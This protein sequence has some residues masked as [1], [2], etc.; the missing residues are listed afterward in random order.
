MGKLQL[1]IKTILIL[2]FFTG[3]CTALNSQTGTMGGDFL[4]INGS[5]RSAA[6][7]GAFIAIADDPSAIYWNPAG[8]TQ[9]DKAQFLSTYMSWLADISYTDLSFVLP[10][11]NNCFGLTVNYL[12]AGQIEE[13]TS[14]NPDGTGRIF[15]PYDYF[16]T[17]SYARAVLPDFSFGI[18]G[19]WI[20]EMLDLSSVAGY[21]FD[22]GLLWKPTKLGTFG[23]SCRNFLGG[24]AGTSVPANYGIGYSYKLKDRFK[25]ITFALDLNLPSDDNM[26]TNFGAEYNFEDGFFVRLGGSTK[27]IS[28][29]YTS[30]GVGLNR[31]KISFDYAY[32]PYGELGAAHR[33][34]IKIIPDIKNLS[35][36]NR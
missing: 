21:S 13:T 33:I 6:M 3:T 31:E 22:L 12:N 8:L 24:F 7:G 23:F 17:L 27:D 30:F 9:M 34:S 26:F 18:G 4:K 25:D 28:N 36:F 1:S 19:K 11:R 20:G 15:S 35:R 14:A 2:V 32:V 29:V 5:A 16:I 10:V